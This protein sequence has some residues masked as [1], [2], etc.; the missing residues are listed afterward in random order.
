MITM[1]NYDYILHFDK[2][3]L[4]SNVDYNWFGNNA[5]DYDMAPATINVVMD[6]WLFL[7][8]T[9]N[10]DAISVSES[11]DILFK[12]YSYSEEDDDNDYDYCNENYGYNNNYG[13]NNNCGCNR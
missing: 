11:S 4:S 13:S 5:T 12:L 7:N 2:R 3:D 9:A 10:P 6:N 8:A 1:N